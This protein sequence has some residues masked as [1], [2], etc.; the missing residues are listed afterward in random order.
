MSTSVMKAK[1]NKYEAVEAN[2]YEMSH[3]TVQQKRER[4]HKVIHHQS[5]SAGKN[6]AMRRW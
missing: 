3:D 1:E 4:K 2:L 6:L 5:S